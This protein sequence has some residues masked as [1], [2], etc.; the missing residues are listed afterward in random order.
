MDDLPNNTPDVTVLL[1]EIQVPKLGW[2]LVEIGVGSEDST[3]FPLGSDNSLY[4]QSLCCCV[5]YMAIDLHPFL[6]YNLMVQTDQ[7]NLTRCSNAERAAQQPR[8]IG[9]IR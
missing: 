7:I 8:T 5:L 9:V 3:R 1:G 6:R 4:D 2:V